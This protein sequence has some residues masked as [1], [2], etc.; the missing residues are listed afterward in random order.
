MDAASDP[1]VEQFTTAYVQGPQT[2]EPGA[3]CTGGLTAP[4]AVVGRPAPR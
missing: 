1:R 2:P 4:G 3:P